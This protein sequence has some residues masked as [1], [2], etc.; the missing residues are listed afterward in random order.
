MVPHMRVTNECYVG[1]FGDNL[2][3]GHGIFKSAD[4][5]IFEG[6]WEDDR[7]NGQGPIYYNDGTIKTGFWENNILR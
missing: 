3:Q 4:G 6:Q 1:R 7:K 5:E 2:R